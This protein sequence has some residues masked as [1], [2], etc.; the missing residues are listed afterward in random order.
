MDKIMQEIQTLDAISLVKRV[1]KAKN[2]LLE[3][4]K[5]LSSE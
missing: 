4:F 3:V 5:K 1:K 2:P